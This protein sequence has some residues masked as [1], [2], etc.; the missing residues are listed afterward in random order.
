MSNLVL[1]IEHWRPG[2]APVIY[3]KFAD[4]LVTWRE[5]WSEFMD[6]EPIPVITGP[7]AQT[8]AASPSSR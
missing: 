1:A 4:D 6:I 7:E 2:A 8:P 3:A 5:H